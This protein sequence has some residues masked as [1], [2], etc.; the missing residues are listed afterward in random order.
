[1]SM[2]VQNDFWLN[3]GFHLLDRDS[4]GNLVVT[5]DFLRAYYLRPEVR[6][7]EDSPALEFELHEELMQTPRL[8][9]SAERLAEIP[10]E[11]VRDNYRVVLDFRARLLRSSSLESCYKGIFAGGD[12]TVPPL[13][14]DQM[15]QIILRNTLEGCEDALQLRAA[16]VFFRK[17]KA[18]VQSGAVMFADFDVIEAHSS[19][20]AFGS[21]GRLISEA[22]TP[23]RNV[24]LDVLEREN[25][26][27][28][29]SR[30]QR[31]DFVVRIN[32]GAPASQAFCA[33][34]ERWV[35]HFSRVAVKVRTI[36]AIEEHHW[37][38]HIG[39]DA[40]STSLLNDLWRGGQVEQGRLQRLLCL[41]RMDFLDH[42]RMRKDIAGR[43]VYLALS[44][45]GD[46]AVRMKPQNLLTNLPVLGQA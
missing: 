33:V 20:A 11:D 27:L 8:G 3:S 36:A 24:S 16:E 29:W 40:E 21:L 32:H 23:L 42:S 34:I 38:W 2:E 37:A 4:D 15:T 10:D 6:P 31:N 41:Y 44:M 12:V 39:L 43:P 18:S 1:M 13:L 17:Q 5:D 22:Q 28:Y 7:M 19:G 14:I 25:A 45:D 30:D 26:D 9:V 46:G 35:S